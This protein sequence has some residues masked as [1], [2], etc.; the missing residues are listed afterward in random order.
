[1]IRRPTCAGCSTRVSWESQY[2]E[3]CDGKREDE[4]NR[5]GLDDVQRIGGFGGVDPD[6]VI[7][8][9][10]GTYSE[11]LADLMAQGWTLDEAREY[12]TSLATQAPRGMASGRICGSEHDVHVV[13]VAKPA[14]TA[15]KAS[16]AFVRCPGSG[17][18]G[19]ARA[20][21]V[22][23]PADNCPECGFLIGVD[24]DGRIVDHDID[25]GGE[26]L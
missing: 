3:R 21:V 6:A 26:Q 18:T 17:L 4:R 2:C 7:L 12:C 14:D 9:D 8:G 16:P 23:V 22:P 24:D 10:G 19:R 11:L 1:M 25:T 13:M 5:A 15:V 20:T